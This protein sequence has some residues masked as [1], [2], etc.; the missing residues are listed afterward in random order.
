MIPERRARGR[1]VASANERAEPTVA[2][3]KVGAER[4]GRNASAIV[5]KK[6][7]GRRRV[8]SCQG[9]TGPGSRKRQPW[10]RRRALCQQAMQ[11]YEPQRGHVTSASRSECSAQLAPSGGVSIDSSSLTGLAPWHA[12]NGSS[13]A[14]SWQLRRERRRPHACAGLP[15]R[16]VQHL[17]CRIG[18]EIERHDD[19]GARPRRWSGSRA[20]T[21]RSLRA[22][23]ALLG[24]CY[25]ISRKRRSGSS[26]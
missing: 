5:A 24:D 11:Q 13:A 7:A 23:P 18:Q 12:R 4:E 1:K 9:T 26:R 22:P 25:A 14:G 19:I 8:A 6:R 21:W 15:L 17:F 10:Q 16:A 2:R 20:D 3:T